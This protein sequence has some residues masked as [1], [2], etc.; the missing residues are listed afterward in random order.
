MGGE[1]K[2]FWAAIA[3]G[4]A[5]GVMGMFAF[6]RRWPTSNGKGQTVRLCEDD[7]QTLREIRDA[8]VEIKIQMGVNAAK[9]DHLIRHQG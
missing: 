5:A 8:L 1:S 4:I 9:L 3:G 2:E 7:R 6:L